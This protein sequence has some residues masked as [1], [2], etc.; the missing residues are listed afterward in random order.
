KR[1][2]IRGAVT[3]KADRNILVAFV[4]RTPGGAAGDREMGTADGIGAHNAV[5]LRSEVHGPTLAAHQ[6]VVALHQ[7]AQY[8]LDRHATRKSV[9]MT[10]VSAERE[11]ALLHGLGKASGDRLLPE[12]QMAG[13]LDQVL[14][15]QVVG[16]LFRLAQ[17]H[18]RAIK[19]QALL[20]AD[21]VIQSGTGLGL[22]A[23]LCCRHK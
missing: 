8:L 19:G 10:A 22:R 20:L 18:L 21:I 23:V 9:G 14:Q 13:A 12:R 17:A 15:E 2:N 11:I 1:T 5:L 3:E 16:A 7:L 4:L 6:P